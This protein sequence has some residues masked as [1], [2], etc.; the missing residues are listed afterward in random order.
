MQCYDDISVRIL[1][2]VHSFFSEN[3]RKLLFFLEKYIRFQHYIVK[4]SPD[5]C[6]ET[7]KPYTHITQLFG[8]HFSTLQLNLL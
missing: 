4:N 7:P 8:V 1:T 5:F 6:I 3:F 2:S